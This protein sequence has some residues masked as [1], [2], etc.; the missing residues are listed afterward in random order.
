M[1]LEGRKY[2]IIENDST[3]FDTINDRGE[4]IVLKRISGSERERRTMRMI[5]AASLDTSEPEIPIATPISAAFRAG[6]SL[7]PYMNQI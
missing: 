3:T 2:Q 4:V 7:T 1:G 6:E 5:S